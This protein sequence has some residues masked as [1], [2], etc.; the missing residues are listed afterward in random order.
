MKVFEKFPFLLG[1]LAS[2]FFLLSFMVK[3]PNHQF[4]S[5]LAGMGI[6]A[7]VVYWIWIVGL[8]LEETRR[9]RFKK[10]LWL[11]VTI[12]APFIGAL[13]YQ[14]MHERLI[15]EQVQEHEPGQEIAA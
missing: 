10:P 14:I 12:S 2:L 8:N 9:N 13:L 6:I 5:E 7:G 15:E 11:F 3:S 4:N 1:L